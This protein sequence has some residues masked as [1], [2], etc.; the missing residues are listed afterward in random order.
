MTFVSN[1]NTNP[2]HYP[3]PSSY[4]NRGLNSAIASSTTISATTTT[5]NNNNNSS[6]NSSSSCSSTNT[7]TLLSTAYS[8]TKRPLA[9]AYGIW[10]LSSHGGINSKCLLWVVIQRMV[11]DS[12]NGALVESLG[13]VLR[14]LL[15]SD[16]LEH[17]TAKVKEDF[18][19]RF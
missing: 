17:C 13:E 5:I 2:N 10:D 1:P 8:S 16:R 6:S 4:L 14:I 18:L 11:T 3:N 12:A 15:D 9:V 7:A 19:A